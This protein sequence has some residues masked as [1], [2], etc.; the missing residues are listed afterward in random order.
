M[1]KSTV[2][3]FFLIAVF[4]IS[5]T[6]SPSCLDTLGIS[7]KKFQKRPGKTN[8]KLNK[9]TKAVLENWQGLHLY[10]QSGSGIQITCVIVPNYHTH[11][12][13]PAIYYLRISPR[14]SARRKIYYWNVCKMH[15]PARLLCDGRHTS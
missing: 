3:T 15:F 10:Y 13:P 4:H 9:P 1:L 12:F 5:I 11:I 2:P 6:R 8:K 7:E 14:N